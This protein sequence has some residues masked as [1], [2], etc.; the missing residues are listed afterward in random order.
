MYTKSFLWAWNIN[1][2]LNEVGV[3][4]VLKRMRSEVTMIA[5]KLMVNTHVLTRVQ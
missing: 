5:F 1:V 4:A 3:K 2:Y